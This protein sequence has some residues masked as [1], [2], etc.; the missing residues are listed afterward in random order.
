MT[1]SRRRPP[2]TFWH[3]FFA[4]PREWCPALQ[5]RQLFIIH[6]ARRI[7]ARFTYPKKCPPPRPVA[8]RFTTWV[9]KKKSRTYRLRW[10]RSFGLSLSVLFIFCNG[11]LTSAGSSFVSNS[12]F[13]S[14]V[15]YLLL[16]FHRSHFD[17]RLYPK[18][19]SPALHSRNASYEKFL[20]T[21]C[22]SSSSERCPFSRLSL[23]PH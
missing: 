2:V 4:R 10:P 7:F 8:S 6:D 5:G 16:C 22:R 1:R 15:V 3:L 11:A 21:H 9:R 23:S 18:K 20:C 14:N 12:P 19:A 13:F 17:R